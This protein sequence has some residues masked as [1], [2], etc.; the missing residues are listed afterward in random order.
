[1]FLYRREGK[2][3]LKLRAKTPGKLRYLSEKDEAFDLACAAL[4]M[5]SIANQN[6]MNS[7]SV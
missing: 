6:I 1:M 5:T 3:C 7:R 4:L 2:G